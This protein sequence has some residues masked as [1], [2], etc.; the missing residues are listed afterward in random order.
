MKKKKRKSYLL[1]LPV[2]SKL[3]P[4]LFLKTIAKN[5]LAPS[6]SHHMERQIVTFA[7]LHFSAM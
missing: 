5:R 6:V 1:S 3:N 2:K 7:L 4:R